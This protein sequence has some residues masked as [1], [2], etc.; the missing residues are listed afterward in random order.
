MIKTIVLQLAG[1]LVVT[2]GF[3]PGPPPQ[4]TTLF[5][6]VQYPGGTPVLFKNEN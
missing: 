5:R 3:A 4:A 2:Y 6:N 1:G